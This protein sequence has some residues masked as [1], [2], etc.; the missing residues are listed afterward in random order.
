MTTDRLSTVVR[1]REL[2][3]REQL[4]AGAV[5]HRNEVHA[6]ARVATAARELAGNDL[7]A[8]TMTQ[9]A[10]L[11]A[12]RLA[13]LALGEQL[14]GAQAAQHA[15]EHATERAELA[16]IEATVARRS[17]ER[18]RDRRKARADGQAAKAASRRDDDLAL[19]SW[20]RSR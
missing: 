3:E 13:A 10:G 8:G 18:L 14:T 1:L 7:P 16:R 12:N 15:A 11:G 5:A 4:V 2:R 6:R 19:Q 9:S 20:R 17:V